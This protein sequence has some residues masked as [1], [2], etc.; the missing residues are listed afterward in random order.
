MNNNISLKLIHIFLNIYKNFFFLIQFE[1]ILSF[2]KGLPIYSFLSLIQ[3]YFVVNT[4][5]RFMKTDVIKQLNWEE[6][7]LVLFKIKEEV[8]LL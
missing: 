4:C 3:K 8:T 2:L 1:S 6:E 7:I 5:I